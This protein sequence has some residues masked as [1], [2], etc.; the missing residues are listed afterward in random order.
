MDNDDFILC[1]TC[2][3]DSVPSKNS[4]VL[5]LIRTKNIDMVAGIN[6]YE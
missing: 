4:A 2:K 3:I 5:H 6:F 1:L